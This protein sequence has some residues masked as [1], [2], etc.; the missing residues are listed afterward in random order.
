MCEH[1]WLLD[2]VDN[3]TIVA[4]CKKYGKKGILP[5]GKKQRKRI[6][7]LIEELWKESE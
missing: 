3:H 6:D 7:M 2:L 5:L 1:E 4:E